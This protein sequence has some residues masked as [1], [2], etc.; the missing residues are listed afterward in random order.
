VVE[1]AHLHGSRPDCIYRRDPE[2]GEALYQSDTAIFGAP[3][4]VEAV[5][6]VRSLADEWEKNLPPGARVVSPLGLGGHVDHRL[7][8][9]TAER[10][11]RKLWYYAD[12]PYA[13]EREGE[14]RGL[15]AGAVEEVVF[16]V[17]TA[18][19]EAWMR[20][21]AAY[22]S[23]FGSFWGSVEEMEGNFRE[24]LGKAGGLRVWRFRRPESGEG[25]I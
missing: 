21:N 17:S 9:A 13:F 8:R 19:F 24:F 10:L 16:P 4:P 1:A 2:S 3:A 7:V 14:I 20:G 23:Q 12:M 11:G 22:A 15:L 18:G 5:E 6:L 25:I